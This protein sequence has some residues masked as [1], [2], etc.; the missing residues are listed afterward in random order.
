MYLYDTSQKGNWYVNK[1]CIQS[2]L[3]GNDPGTSG[4]ESIQSDRE[5]APS[6]ARTAVRSDFGVEMARAEIDRGGRCHRNLGGRHSCLKPLP[7]CL[8]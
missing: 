7:P 2:I 4:L 3:E 5:D 6:F 8:K 1:D